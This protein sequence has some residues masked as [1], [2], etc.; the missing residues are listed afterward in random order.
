MRTIHADTKL[1]NKK[2]ILLI[3]ALAFLAIL[4]TLMLVAGYMLNNPRIYKGIFIGDID[5]GGLSTETAFTTVAEHYHDKLSQTV[6][7]RSGDMKIELDLNALNA[8]LDAEQTAQLAYRTAR[9][10]STF[11]RL[12]E[13][14]SLWTNPL[15][16]PPVIACDET[17]LLEAV[18]KIADSIDEPG[19]DMAIS[20]GETELMITRGVPGFSINQDKAMQ[21]FKATALTLSDNIF[22]I[23]PERVLPTVPIANDIYDE[24]CGEPIDAT[25]TIENQRLVITDEQDGISFDKV[26]AQRIIDETSGDVI[27]IPITKTPAAITAQEL[28]ANLFPDLLGSY[29]T[30]YNAG[31]IARSHNVSLAAE[32]INQVVLAPG[33][34]FSYN[35]TVGPR[36]AARGFRTANVYV[37][38]KIEPGIGGGICQVSSTLFNA[39]V[40]ADLKIEQRT[41]H[42]LP[43]SYVPLG[44]DATVSYGSVDFKFSNNTQAPIKIVASASG[45]VNKISVFGTKANQNRTIDITTE[46][47]GTTTAKVVQKENPDLPV[48][49]IEVEQKG[50]NGSSHNTYKIIKENGRIIKSELLT[51]ST[52]VASDR[53]EIIGTAPLPESVDTVAEPTT[54]PAEETP[55]ALAPPTG[56]PVEVTDAPPPVVPTETPAAQEEGTIL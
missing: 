39:V 28:E 41:N 54:A 1:P 12:R 38:N 10:G 33:D 18:H 42:S 49:T 55:S 6:T 22:S 50:S 8:E 4:F 32:K 26:A 51:K 3:V 14:I 17:L 24:I 20:I 13:M 37:G 11:S 9:T 34:V 5:V 23:E 46:C 31:D 40:L 47:T 36:T 21:D 19:Q 45:G 48:G 44:R 56:Q 29:S 15:V 53:I 7:L 2:K 30:R 27:T 35:T 25:Y 16:L 52:Y 43:V